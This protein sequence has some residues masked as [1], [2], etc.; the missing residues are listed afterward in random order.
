MM[1]AF[2]GRIARLSSD[3]GDSPRSLG[4]F[5]QSAGGVDPLCRRIEA[6][7]PEQHRRQVCWAYRVGHRMRAELIAGPR[8]VAEWP[9]FTPPPVSTAQE[10]SGQW[11]RPTSL[12]IFGVQPNLS[13]L[14]TVAAAALKAFL[15]SGC[16]KL[17][18][19]A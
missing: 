7:R 17:E 13:R 2:L 1:A 3:P 10:Q 9:A 4:E 15:W 6:E 5:V 11:S 8:G 16:L 14:I 19:A 12:L 18:V